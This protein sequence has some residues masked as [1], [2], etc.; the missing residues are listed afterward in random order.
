[1]GHVGN[2]LA[3][4]E[5]ALQQIVDEGVGLVVGEMGEQL[6]LGPAWQVRARLWSRD[7][8]FRKMLLLLGHPI[9]RC[10]CPL[11]AT[12]V[13]ASAA[14]QVQAQG[15]WP[16][17]G[18]AHIDLRCSQKPTGANDQRNCEKD[19]DSGIAQLDG[20][21]GGPERFSRTEQKSAG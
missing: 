12:L 2:V 1:V 11:S 14:N 4:A 5:T 20:K 9:R 8:K 17:S 7:I 13:E 6:T 15:E 10:R 18:A 16:A 3:A 21:D 19:I